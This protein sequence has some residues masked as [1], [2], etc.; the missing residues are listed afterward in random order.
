MPRHVCHSPHQTGHAD[1]PHPAFTQTLATQRYA[2]RRTDLA[3]RPKPRS[4]MGTV[5]NLT[6]GFRRGTRVQAEFPPSDSACLR[7]GPFAPRSLPASPLLRAGPTPAPGHSRVMHSP[8]VLAHSRA[9]PGWV[10]QVPRL[11]CPHAPSPTTPESPMVACTHCFTI[12]GRLHHV[13]QLGRSRFC[14]TRPNRVRLRY[15]SRVRLTRLRVTDYSAPRGL[16]YLL[17]GQLQGKLLP[18]YKIS[19]AY[20]GTPYITRQCMRRPAV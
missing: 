18:A 17:N 1:F 5:P 14:V 19:Q 2:G 8:A 20:P 12:G 4:K 13:W 3:R 7:S 9:P 10:S 16:G 6:A 11:I 15:G